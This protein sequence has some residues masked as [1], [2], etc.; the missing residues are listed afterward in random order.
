MIHTRRFFVAHMPNAITTKPGKKYRSLKR[1]RVYEALRRDGYDKTSAARIS[2]AQA[3]KRRHKAYTLADLERYATKADA[4]PTVTALIAAQ[5]PELPR[6]KG[7]QIAPGITRIHGDLCNVHGRYGSCGAATGTPKPAPVRLAKPGKGG[8]GR[9][10]RQP[11]KAAKPKKTDAERQTERDQKR[12]ANR[13]AVK[14]QMAANDAGLGPSGT[15]ALLA[16]SDGQQPNKTMGD[17]LVQM[18]L[19]ELAS[20][21]TYRMTPTGHAAVAGLNAGDYQRTVD[22]VS[23]GTDAKKR[24]IERQQ[25]SDARHQAADQRKR[26][27][28]AKRQQRQARSSAGGRG[29]STPQKRDTTPAPTPHKPTGNRGPARSSGGSGPRVDA[30]GN[31][32]KRRQARERAQQAQQRQVAA[33]ER[34][35]QADERRRQAEDRQKVQPALADAAKR[36]ATGETI[37][38][39]ATMRL[40]KNGLARY[41]KQGTLV[42]T[43][44]GQRASRQKAYTPRAFTPTRMLDAGHT[45]VMVALIPD[46]AAL[47]ALADTEG[48]TEPAD[49]LH[50]TLCYLG[51]SSEQPLATNKA[52][53][54]DAVASWATAHGRT[55]RGEINGAGRFFHSEDDGTNAV[56]VSPDVPGLPELRQTLVEAIESAGFDYAQNH[57]FTPHI[58]VAYVPEEAPT[59][60][61][62]ISTPVIFDHATL[63]WGDEQYDFPLGVRGTSLTVLKDRAGRYR[64]VLLSSNA[65]R[66]RDGEIVSTKA[67]A[68]DCDRADADG[69]YGPL[70]WW[71]VPG[72]DIGDCDFNAMQGRIL[73]ES[74]TFRD[75]R[76]GAAIATKARDLQVS[77][78]FVHPMDEPDAHGVFHHIRR[79]ERSLVPTGRA[80]NPFTHVLIQEQPTMATVKERLDELV[81]LLGS[82]ELAQQVVAAAE[83]TQKALDGEGVAFKSDTAPAE[84]TINGVVYTVKA[85]APPVAAEVKAPA[86]MMAMTPDAETP[87]ETTAEGGAEE[88]GES[89]ITLSPGDLQAI[90]DVITAALQGY[91]GA[92][93]S[94][95][96]EL[97][98]IVQQFGYARQKE[99]SDAAAKVDAIDARLKTLEGDQ[100][101]ATKGY[102]AS[103]DAAT[104]PAPDRLKE[105]Q[106]AAPP[107]DVFADMQQFLRGMS[108][109]G[110]GH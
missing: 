51:D 77:I 108:Q 26:D 32:A 7:E 100:P 78:G 81:R 89:D 71:H 28:E 110:V 9:K 25:A 46:A 101:I 10:P 30:G 12:Q 34:Q 3:K 39:A 97:D 4:D 86:A 43:S 45:G 69:S 105:L 67:L 6:L 66:D 60:P 73:V 85:A 79:F 1:P 49:Q 65:Y 11:R 44:A 17:G 40:I 62:R 88:P 109:N 16:F 55:L 106:P 74:G 103:T 91:G 50:L 14:Q 90:S 54:I 38:D 82:A 41:D 59:P 64:W 61:I 13:D 48:V 58:T 57:G 24:Q 93:T 19:A 56:F 104:V 99:A 75:E 83:T 23:R 47:Q 22:A 95:V 70:R 52:R 33:D 76:I 63:A 107:E 42:L 29:R 36:Y 53:V 27:A 98:G 35:R 94:K 102:R 5:L 31:A 8:K 72:V 15:D 87:A 80:A 92:L 2:N 96:A 18:G 21:G 84:I 68:D 37:D 20:D